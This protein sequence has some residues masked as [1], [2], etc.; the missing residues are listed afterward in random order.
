M[1]SLK[2]QLRLSYKLRLEQGWQTLLAYPSTKKTVCGLLVNTKVQT[3]KKHV[4][5]AKLVKPW[6]LNFV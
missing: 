2:L 1:P 6:L 3:E 4:L 5:Q